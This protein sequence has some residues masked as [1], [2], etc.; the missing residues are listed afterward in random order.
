MPFPQPEMIPASDPQS[1]DPSGIS[2]H[3]KPGIKRRGL[4][5]GALSFF[6]AAVGTLGERPQATA[7]QLAL[8][9]TK[10][11]IMTP[12]DCYVTEL[13]VADGAKVSAGQSIA[14]LDTDEEDRVIDRISLAAKLLSLQEDAISDHQITIRRNVFVSTVNVA[15]LYLDYATDRYDTERAKI[16]DVPNLIPAP[17]TAITPDT[18]G[19][20]TF[21]LVLQQAAAVVMRA[22]AEV[23]RANSA[24]ELFDFNVAQARAKLALI[25]SQLPKEKTGIDDRKKRL[26]ITAPVAGSIK[27]SCYRGAFLPKGTIMAEIS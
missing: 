9:I 11:S 10:V 7:A 1:N 25:K 27:F 3:F 4:A 16:I 5:Y 8:P 19:D 6:S 18:F 12:K 17:G 22:K 15:R 13:L 26:S 23:D 20:Q 14:A 2:P 24:L 21:K